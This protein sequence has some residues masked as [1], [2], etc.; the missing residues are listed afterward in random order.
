MMISRFITEKR[1]HFNEFRAFFCSMYD[2]KPVQNKFEA[3]CVIFHCPERID[4]H[5]RIQAEGA[6][7]GV[8]CLLITLACIE[9]YSLRANC[10]SNFF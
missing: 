8:Q 10:V 1:G 6:V 2:R 4:F 3:R 9:N 7:C 5:N